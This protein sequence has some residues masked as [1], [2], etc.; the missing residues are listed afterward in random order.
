MASFPSACESRSRFKGYEIDYLHVDTCEVRM[1]QEGKNQPSVA[2]ER[3]PKLAFARLYR[4]VTAP[5]AP[6]FLD[7]LVLIP[8]L[9]AFTQS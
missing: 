9:I 6:A 3:T 7:A 1:P 2:V 8:F 4:R 5:T